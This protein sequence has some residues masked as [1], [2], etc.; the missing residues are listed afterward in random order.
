[1]SWNRCD[2]WTIGPS[3]GSSVGSGAGCQSRG[4]KFE[5]RLG[6]LSFRRLTKVN[7]TCLVHLPP[8]G[9]VYVEK[10]PVAW[11]DCCVEYW[12]ENTRKC[13]S[14]WTCRRDITEKMLKTALNPN[15]SINQT[16]TIGRLI[17]KQNCNHY[18]KRRNCEL[19][20]CN[21]V[22]YRF[23][24]NFNSGVCPENIWIKEVYV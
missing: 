3:P 16:W 5:S 20:I 13:M 15:K 8:M 2:T 18:G 23:F 7:A 12:C 21:R 9:L 6:Q 11:E 1:M 14:R 4:C 22:K 10:Q 17:L 24:I 19:T